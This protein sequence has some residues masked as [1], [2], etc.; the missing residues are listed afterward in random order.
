MELAT[1]VTLGPPFRRM[2][3]SRTATHIRVAVNGKVRMEVPCGGDDA[4][5]NA[6]AN[7]QIIMEILKGAELI[8]ADASILDA[9]IIRAAVRPVADAMVIESLPDV[10][11]KSRIRPGATVVT[12]ASSPVVPLLAWLQTRGLADLSKIG[13]PEGGATA[14]QVTCAQLSNLDMRALL[15]AMS[16]HYPDDIVEWMREAGVLPSPPRMTGFDPLSI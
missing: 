2:V 1:L 12:F 11:G 9:P 13:Q 16:H 14:G 10:K 8:S 6:I 5:A 15:V 3:I 7:E 4:K